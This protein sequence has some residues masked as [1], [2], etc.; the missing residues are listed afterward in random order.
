M[1]FACNEHEA[2]KLHPLLVAATRAQ[3][4]AHRCYLM[5]VS[6]THPSGPAGARATVSATPPRP[7]DDK[8]SSFQNRVT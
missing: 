7:T 3:Q 5:N 1:Q 6:G 4:R 8:Y 2:C